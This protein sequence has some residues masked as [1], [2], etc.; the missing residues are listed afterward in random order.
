MYDDDYYR[1]RGSSHGVVANVM[2]SKIIV[3]E[4]ELE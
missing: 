2:D 1:R 4:F 3:R